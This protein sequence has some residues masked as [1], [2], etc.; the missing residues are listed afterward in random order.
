MK[1]MVYT[2]YGSP[3]VLQFRD[4]ETPTPKDNEVLIKI[5]AASA[6]AADWHLLRGDPFLLRLQFGLRKPKKQIL[7]ADIAG[8]S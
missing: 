5:H 4:V 1:A 8:T 7:G 2:H 3:E 6:N